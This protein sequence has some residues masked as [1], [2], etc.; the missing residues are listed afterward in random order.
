M[1]FHNCEY[2][3]FF[4]LFDFINKWMTQMPSGF[5]SLN[6]KTISIYIKIIIDIY[7]WTIGIYRWN[8]RTTKPVDWI[9]L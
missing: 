8:F 7:A 2:Y 5:I 1:L 4:E 9:I 3:L 6:G